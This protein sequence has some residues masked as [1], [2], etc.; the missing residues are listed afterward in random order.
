MKIDWRAPIVVGVV[1]FVGTN[2]LR[3]GGEAVVDIVQDNAWDHEVQ[4]EVAQVK[5]VV[6]PIVK[7]TQSLAID[8]K[9]KERAKKEKLLVELGKT[10]PEQRDELFHDT[11]EDI[12]DGKA[13]LDDEIAELRQLYSLPVFE[14]NE[15]EDDGN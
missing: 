10:P 5:R 14:A 15:G 11:L 3:S 9:A 2:F 1:V 12:Q 13:E 7:S 8:R 6:E 4:E